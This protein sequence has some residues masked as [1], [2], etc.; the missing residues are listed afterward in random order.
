MEYLL[1]LGL[2]LVAGVALGGG[3]VWAYWR[4]RALL[5]E[6]QV[7]AGIGREAEQRFR[8]ELAV[9]EERLSGRDLRLAQARE[10]LDR[11]DGQ[12][13]ELQQENS[14]LT[15][16]VSELTERLSG[17]RRLSQEKQALL[18]EARRELADSFKALSG[19]IFQQNS[20]S[21]MELAKATFGR[22]QERAGGELEQRHRAISEMVAPLK[23]SLEKVDS[24]L[25]QVEK[26]R[27]DA[28]AGLNEQVRTLATSQA[29]LQ[30]ET[31]NLV[32]ALR[33]PQVR[34]R[35]GE[36]QLRRVVE[37]AGMLEY[38]DFVQQES[39]QGP[40]GRL[41]PDMLIKLPN[42]KRIVVDSK[43][44]LSAYLE[45]IESDDEETRNCKMRE[46]SRQ[47]RT[48]L[49]Q[50]SSKS[51]WEQ[52]QPSPEFVVL[53]VPGEN[54]FSAAL[55][56]DPELIEYGV[57]RRVILATPTT[58]IALLRAV[59][60]GWRQEKIADHAH[61]IGQLGRSLYDRL[62][63]MA[64]H[65]QAMRRGLSG[66]VDS[67]NRAVGSL[68]TRVLVTARKFKELD[69]GHDKE[70]STPEVLDLQPRALNL[71]DEND[72]GGF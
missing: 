18:M 49:T 55:E 29:R 36:I 68:E 59:S 15:S 66:A 41:R 24:Q 21:F 12:L 22:M 64:N 57:N 2:A 65:F 10:E 32:R 1:Q 44:A 50:L 4:R 40:E 23:E 7:A 26:E 61:E 39:T 46:H 70:L 3:V 37:M 43:A 33:A 72:T 8:G 69:P 53:F 27:I 48:H 6:E 31:A 58:L 63:V 47:I 16:R 30:G 14:Q 60:Y 13:A 11:L 19:D 17:E 56:Q 25:R 5:R 45:A 35:W 42:D 54:F 67:Y 51:Y 71:P 20:R 62:C 9:W 34:G 38:C 28:Y 52:F